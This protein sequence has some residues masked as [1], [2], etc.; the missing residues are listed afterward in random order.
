MKNIPFHKPFISNKEKK[1]LNISLNNLNQSSKKVYS[2]KCEIFL[3]KKLNAKKVFIVNSCT[4]ALEI[5]AHLLKIKNGDEV[6]LP[7]YTFVSTANAFLLR[8]AKLKFADVNL[9]DMNIDPKKVEKLI[10]KK[11]K[12]IVLVHYAGSP[13][14]M[15]NFRKLEKKYSIPIIEDAAQAL[16]AKYNNKFLGTFSKFSAL[17]FHES[18][19]IT[20]GEGGALIINDKQ[21]IKQASYIINKGTN[22]E[23]FNNKLKKKYTWVSVGSSYVLSELNSSILYAQLQKLKYINFRRKKIWNKYNDN[24]QVL[25]SKGHLLRQ[26]I[27]LKGK[28]NAHIYFVLLKSKKTRDRFISFM[29]ERG[30]TCLFHYVP[31]DSSPMGKKLNKFQNNCKNTKSGFERLVRFPIWLGIEKYQDTII[32]LTKKFF[33]LQ[34]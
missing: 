12:A 29:K 9:N 31:L 4:S 14:D 16:G 24:F 34:K 19:N 6:I 30:V 5:I 1:Y 26:K 17:S 25:E 33:N 8:G 7:S 20:S 13:C 28:N 22:R 18:K 32:L 21:Y 23:E 10:T 11:T 15:D 2:K 27:N 3:E